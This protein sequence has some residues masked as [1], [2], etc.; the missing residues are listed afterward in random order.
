MRTSGP[1]EE[2]FLLVPQLSV[3]F[4]RPDGGAG[5]VVLPSSIK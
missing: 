3:R 2:G 4:V 5:V 1:A